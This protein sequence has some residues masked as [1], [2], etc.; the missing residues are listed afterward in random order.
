M[1]V[2]ERRRKNNIRED[3]HIVSPHIGRRAKL[4]KR[5]CQQR[6]ELRK[7]QCG[8]STKLISKMRKELEEH[9]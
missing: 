6:Y 4:G 8:N 7:V 9:S 3:R 5:N 1:N 2:R